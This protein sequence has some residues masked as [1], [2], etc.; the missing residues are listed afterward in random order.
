MYGCPQAT[1]WALLNNRVNAGE[2]VLTLDRNVGS[3]W[4]IGDKIAIAAT[5]YDTRETERAVITDISVDGMTVTLDRNLSFAHNGVIDTTD[6]FGHMGAE[7][8]H[9][10]RNIVIDGLTDSDDMFGGRVV[11]LKSDNGFTYRKGWAQIDNVEFSNMGQFGQTNL[12]DF[13]S[14]V[15]FYRIGEQDDADPERSFVTNRYLRNFR[16]VTTRLKKQIM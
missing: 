4:K 15:F 8:I 11:V 16:L 6:Y 3:D 10:S 12:E 1:P 7:I 14:P 2:N 9:L 5:S 13:R